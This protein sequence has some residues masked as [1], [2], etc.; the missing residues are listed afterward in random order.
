MIKIN[1]YLYINILTAALFVLGAVFHCLMP[2]CVTYAVMLLHELSHTL[3]AVCIG[4]KISCITFHPFGVSLKLKNKIV[5]SLSDEV[6]LYIS[7]PLCNIVLALA[8][9][10]A[11]NRFPCESLRFFYTANIV[12]FIMNMLPAVPLDGGIILRRVLTRF[13][14]S[15]AAYK[16]MMAVS[17]LTGAAVSCVGITVLYKTGFN[18]SVLMFSIF[19]I[20]NALVQKEKYNMDFVRELMFHSKKSKKKLYHSIAR[21]SESGR[22]MIKRFSPEKYN[23]VYVTDESGKIKNILT[24][25][26]II[27]HLTDTNITV[28]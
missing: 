14:G 15:G 25:E 4:L 8:A 5:Y 10:A 19:I 20:G 12:L 17:V 16:L 23:I 27:N 3:A 24:E 1:R 6:I 11:Y 7:G 18:F 9:A 21:E 22:D 2:V 26:E 28:C 13:I